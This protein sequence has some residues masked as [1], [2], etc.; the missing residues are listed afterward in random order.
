MAGGAGKKK[1]VKSVNSDRFSNVKYLFSYAYA[2][3][4][5]ISLGRV[6]TNSLCTELQLR[7]ANFSFL[8]FRGKWGKEKGE[9]VC[10]SQQINIIHIGNQQLA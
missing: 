4:L 6:I 10:S 8:L 3:T 5:L 1:T 9:G 2:I 7:R